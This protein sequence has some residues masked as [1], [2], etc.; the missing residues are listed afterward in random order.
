MA[1][2]HHSDFNQFFT[3]LWGADAKPFTWQCELAEKVTRPFPV[4]DSEAA[5]QTCRSE[6]TQSWPD[7][8]AL[9][10]GAGKTACLDI[11]VFALAICARRTQ[12]EAGSAVAAPRRIFFV[13]DRRIIVDA[14]YERAR[15]LAHK[16]E[17][18]RAGV[19]KAV[20][21]ELMLMACGGRAA[22]S[23][24]RPLA[25]H[26]LRGG[27][28]RS[29][30]WVTNPLQP[31]I[32]ASTVDQIGSR[33][34]FRAYGRGSSTWPI[35]AGLIANDSLILLDEAHC[36]Q[37][38]LQTLQAVSKY[39]RWADEPIGRPFL[40]VVMSATPPLGVRSVFRDCSGE[41]RNP[42]HP[43]GRRQLAKKPAR[44][45]DPVKPRKGRGVD[46]VAKEL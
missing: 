1:K 22:M 5:H 3:E 21:D 31:T 36:A 27:M 13:V 25:V 9:P 11:A 35:Y 7:A 46:T 26:S 37:P 20:A 16:L 18:A 45:A 8:I 40:P 14:A 17:C 38:F 2:L 41:G 42:E 34:L 4:S 44:L 15:C 12:S 19:L 10:T 33:L 32:V 24:E 39:R 6:D 28:Y 29:D 23:G 30:G 43:L